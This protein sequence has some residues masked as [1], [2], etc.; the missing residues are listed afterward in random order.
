MNKFY[1]FRMNVTYQAFLSHYSGVASTVVVMT[2]QGLKLQLP[3]SRFRSFLTQLGVKGRFRLT[4]DQ[5]NRFVNL[6]QVG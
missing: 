3:A 4:V 1:Y 5:H 6:E 2:E